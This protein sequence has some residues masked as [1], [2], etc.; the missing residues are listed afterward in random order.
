MCDPFTF[1]IDHRIRHG[2]LSMRLGRR[3]GLMGSA[4]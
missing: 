4:E 3:Y 1:G 2:V